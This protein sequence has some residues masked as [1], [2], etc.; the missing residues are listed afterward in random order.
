ML[1]PHG[2]EAA[3]AEYVTFTELPVNPTAAATK[4]PR[5]G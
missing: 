4:L 2:L 3:L 5:K 1:T